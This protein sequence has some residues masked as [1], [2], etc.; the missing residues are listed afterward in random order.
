MKNVYSFDIFDTVL[1][2]IWAKPHHLFWRLGQELKRN[3]LLKISLDSW[4]EI[5]RN[6]ERQVRHNSQQEEITLREIYEN[7]A[8][9]LNWSDSEI[10]SAIALEIEL[11]KKSLFVVP[12]IYQKIQ[13]YRQEK[14]KIIYISDMYLSES[15]IRELLE[16][17]QCWEEKDSLYISSELKLT[18]ASGNLFSYC[19]QQESLQNRKLVHQGDNF[20]SDIQVPR[21]LGVRANFFD[22]TS[23][24]R[25]EE[26]IANSDRLP[27]ELR[28]IL[29]GSSRLTRLS[30][31]SL[32]H[33]QN[34]IWETVASA[35][36]PVLFGFV[37]WCL[38][39]ARDRE[40]ERLYFV[41]RDGQILLKIAR[42]LCTN[43]EYTID[44]RYL[45]GSRQAWHFPAIQEIGEY[46]LNWLFDPTAFLSV[47][48]LCKR[49]N[50]EPEEIGE[51]LRRSG[52][53]PSCWHDNLN[54]EE[55]NSLKQVFHNREAIAIIL[56][57]S[58]EFRKNALGYFQQEGLADPIRFGIVDIGWNGRLQYSL[59]R[60]LACGEMYPQEGV[61]GFYFALSRRFKAFESEKLLSYFSDVDRPH[62]ERDRL[63]YY[64]ELFELFVAADHGGTIKFA[65]EGEMYHPVLRSK[66]N[67]QAIQWGLKIQQE[68]ITKFCEIFTKNL[69]KQQYSTESGLI[70]VEILLKEFI[71]NPNRSEAD[72]FGSFTVA[73]DQNETKF[74]ELAPKYNVMRSL[75]RL[76]FN[77][78]ICHSVW[79]PAIQVRSSFLSRLLIAP[80]SLKLRYSIWQ[81]LVRLGQ[82]LQFNWGMKE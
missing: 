9:S 14:H 34:I 58:A 45:Y 16:K 56:E 66:L 51:L 4:Y 68:A 67:E 82:F 64:R 50:L 10:Q 29:A 80:L 46:E 42:I 75:Y 7:L 23:L 76:L 78:D 6:S 13:K 5:R 28:S 61:Y 71:K 54:S 57:R 37:F 25:Y 19:L 11:E 27:L 48:S 39:E 52:F 81:K 1:V 49:I 38:Q 73:E 33:S 12:E 2:R 20:Y 15:S 3:H 24:N 18:K 55:R 72:V 77:R 74:H 43:W 22:K 35:I 40:V 36:A 65:K 17:H 41:A 21:K 30:S 53:S 31:D 32:T 79:F 63:C 26:K 60:L 8:L 70:G 44:C 69:D 59:S 62:E 47:H